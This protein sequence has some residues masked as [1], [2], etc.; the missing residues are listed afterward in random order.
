MNITLTEIL[1]MPLLSPPSTASYPVLGL[2]THLKYLSKSTSTQIK[3]V[4]KYI[5]RVLIFSS[6]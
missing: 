3:K 4:L 2:S 6:T 5:E 1:A